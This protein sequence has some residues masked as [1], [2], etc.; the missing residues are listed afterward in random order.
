[1]HEMSLA[2]SVREIIED[3]ARQE[4]FRR[5]KRVTLEIGRLSSVEPEAMRFCFDVVMQGSVAC[6]A[7]LEI[8]E[9]GGLGQC[10]GCKKTASL[11]TLYETCPFCGALAMQVIA[12]DAMK[13][14]TLEVE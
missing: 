9:V 6:D 1:M 4:G 13:V 2:E 14:K 8:I 3:S 7:E 12:G 11:E 10:T 5:V